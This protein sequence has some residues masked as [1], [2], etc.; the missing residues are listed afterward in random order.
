MRDFGITIAW[1]DSLFNL[2]K[3]R[4]IKGRKNK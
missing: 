3:L 4:S 1:G 2:C